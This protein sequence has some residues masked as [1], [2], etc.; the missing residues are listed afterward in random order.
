MNN[1][2][3]LTPE[4]MEDLNNGKSIVIEPPKPNITKWEPKREKICVFLNSD[5]SSNGL[6]YQTQSQANNAAKA[7]RS[8]A[9]QLAWLAEN[10]DGWI[11]DWNDNSQEKYYISYNYVSNKNITKT[12]GL[13]KNLS[14]IYMSKQNAEKLCK[15]LNDGIVEF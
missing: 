7:V 2:I 3:T 13:H 10:E 4:Q 15:L 5:D 1:T 14:T 9:R 8:Y 6:Q 11:A 12:I